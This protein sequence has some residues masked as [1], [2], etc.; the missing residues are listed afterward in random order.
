MSLPHLLSFNLRILQNTSIDKA[1]QI[2]PRGDLELVMVKHAEV[3]HTLHMYSTFSPFQKEI[4][5]IFWIGG[6]HTRGDRVMDYLFMGPHRSMSNSTYANTTAPLHIA[7][8][9]QNP[10]SCQPFRQPGH[11]CIPRKFTIF[12]DWYCKYTIQTHFNTWD[13]WVLSHIQYNKSY[14]HIVF[15]RWTIFTQIGF[16]FLPC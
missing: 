13:P 8:R 12:I 14:W 11:L 16:E 5:P 1:T 3:I 6:L 15:T 4:S 10:T 7:Y 9:R 2:K